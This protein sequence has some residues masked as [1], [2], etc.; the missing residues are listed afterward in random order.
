MDLT[1][2]QRWVIEV[3]DR[4]NLVWNDNGKNDLRPASREGVGVIEG[5]WKHAKTG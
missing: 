5:G 1:I 2:E 3:S 4:D